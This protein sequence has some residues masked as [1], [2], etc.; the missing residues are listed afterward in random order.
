MS[1]RLAPTAPDWEGLLRTLRRQGTPE[2]V[3]IFEHGIA[4]NIQAAIAERHGLWDDLT[5]AW[6]PR[7]LA[8]HRHLGI[9]LFRIFPEGGRISVARL[10]EGWADESSG[11]I[12][13]W[14]SFEAFDWPRPEDADLSVMDAIE[15]A[16]PDNMRAFHVVDIWE[17]VRDL[18][19]FKPFCYALFEQPDLVEAV[20]EK[21]GTFVLRIAETLCDYDTFGAVY[22]ADD[23][24]YKTSTMIS[25]EA[26]R[27][28]ILPW[29]QRLADQTHA[30]GK[31]FFFHS[32]GQMYELLDTYIDEVKIDAK[33]SFEDNVLPV[34]E[35]K[36]RWGERLSLLGGVD[37]DF[38]A[39]AEEAAIRQLTREILDTCHPGGGYCLGSGNWVTH[40]IPLDNY[41]AML[42]EAQRWTS[43]HAK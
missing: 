31:L 27:Q 30:R 19:G 20:F 26:I 5:E 25:P 39:R 32:C 12:H 41:L 14:T 4:D 1:L 35:V 42:D 40:Y 33:H 38:L 21:V 29:H 15:A 36:Q 9:E 18:F 28:F 13:D 43:E 22:L 6:L 34:T 8:V 10:R 17:V 37:V 23:L 7:T 16:P 11:P 2:R 24:G 3:Y